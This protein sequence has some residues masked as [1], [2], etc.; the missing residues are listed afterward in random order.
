MFYIVGITETCKR[1]GVFNTEKQA[2]RYIGTLPNHESGI[3]YIDPCSTPVIF[4]AEGEEPADADLMVRL[5]RAHLQAVGKGDQGAWDVW[6]EVTYILGVHDKP[7]AP[8]DPEL[9]ELLNDLDGAI[10]ERNNDSTFMAKLAEI[11]KRDQG[12]LDR[13]R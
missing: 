10:E 3:Y 13:L 5:Y 7:Q 4:G 1:L 8:L 6:N 11:I 12:I 9:E 2:S